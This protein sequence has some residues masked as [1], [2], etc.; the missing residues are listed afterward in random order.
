MIGIHQS[1]FLAWVP[2][3]YKI[4][5]SDIFIVLDDVQYQKNGVQNRNQMKTP[6]GAL[7]LTLPII[8]DFGQNINETKLADFKKNKNK[9]L[10]TIEMSY[11]KSKYYNEI[12]PTLTNIFESESLNLHQ[13]NNEILLYF[14]KLLKIDTEIRYSSEF[15]TVGKKDDLVLELIN[16][17]SKAPLKQY[18]SGSGGLEYMDLEK[19]KKNNIEIFLCEFHYKEYQQLWNKLG[20]IENLSIIDLLFNDLKNAKEYINSCGT[21]KEI[22]L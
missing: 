6:N 5:K 1:Q 21:L 18:I 13:I 2:Y 20:F 17:T 19:F 11:S 8:N 22:E 16:L 3:Y 4:L 10:K 14:L 12:M 15:N 9:V 7:W